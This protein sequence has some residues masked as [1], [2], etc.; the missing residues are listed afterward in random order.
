MGLLVFPAFAPLSGA[1]H[2]ILMLIAL[3]GTLIYLITDPPASRRWV[4]RFL[5]P[6][7]ALMLLA[8]VFSVDPRWVLFGGLGIYAGTC[9]WGVFRR[10]HA[11]Y[12]AE[13]ERLR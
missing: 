8:R 6:L 7:V 1:P 10:E 5:V 13:R 4:A 9:L 11:E 3:G 12:L 2:E